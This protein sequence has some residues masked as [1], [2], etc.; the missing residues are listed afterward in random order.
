VVRGAKVVSV[1]SA[2]IFVACAK[3]VRDPIGRE[4]DVADPKSVV[5]AIFYAARTGDATPLPGLCAPDG[6][7]DESVRRICSLT[8]GDPAWPSF[9]VAFARARLNGEPRVHED[10]AWLDFV[11]GERA[12]DLETME[13]ARRADR[14]YLLRF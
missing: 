8:P 11:F 1:A 5:G 4:V 3:E 2:T 12:T 6:E 10:H 13:L 7:S 14:W 9:R